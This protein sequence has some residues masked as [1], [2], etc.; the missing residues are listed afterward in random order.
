MR[1]S[2]RWVAPDNI[3]NLLG[4]LL[5]LDYLRAEVDV[6]VRLRVLRVCLNVSIQFARCHASQVHPNDVRRVVREVVEQQSKSELQEPQEGVRMLNRPPSKHRASDSR[7]TQCMYRNRVDWHFRSSTKTKLTHHIKVFGATQR[8]KQCSMAK[9]T[10]GE[11][12]HT[13]RFEQEFA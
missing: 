10:H 7:R 5:R 8:R 1:V 9:L 11:H 13:R 6:F 4:V 12:T 3:P 2:W